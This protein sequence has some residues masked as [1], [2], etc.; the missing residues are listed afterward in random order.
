MELNGCHMKDSS[1]K[2]KKKSSPTTDS[3]QPPITSSLLAWDLNEQPIY[4]QRGNRN[5]GS[6]YQEEAGHQFGRWTLMTQRVF[7]CPKSYRHMRVQCVC[8][9]IEFRDYASLK[10]GTSMGCDSCARADRKFCRAPKWLVKRMEAAKDRCT[11]KANPN[12]K[13]YGG[14]GIKFRFK[15]PAHA[16]NWVLDHLGLKRHL[17]LDRKNNNGH[18]EEWNLRYATQRMQALN[19]RIEKMDFIYAEAEWPYCKQTTEKYLRAGYTREKI[20]T[21]AAFAVH[22][23]RKGWRRI[24]KRLQPLIS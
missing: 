1:I 20:L 11:N 24:Q 8:K 13:H 12:Y 18:Y 21:F 22:N 2:G 4:G 7:L 14:R 3:L 10:K 5:L 9:R 23:K 19:S 6:L 17:T 15:S 16:A